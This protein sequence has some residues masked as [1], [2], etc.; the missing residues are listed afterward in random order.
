MQF[1]RAASH[2]LHSRQ[3]TWNVGSNMGLTIAA[4]V[5]FSGE[6]GMYERIVD[7]GSTL[8]RH[9]DS[10]LLSRWRD[11][12]QLY[13]AITEKVSAICLRCAVLRLDRCICSQEDSEG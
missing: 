12:S 5:K 8:E 4:E 7:F 6:A 11:S 1:N 9:H 2:Y 10:F 13:A 3:R